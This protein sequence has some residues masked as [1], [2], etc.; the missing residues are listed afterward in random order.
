MARR[1]RMN[2]ATKS[3][4]EKH[5]EK[6]LKIDSK[7]DIM[8]RAHEMCRQFKAAG[9]KFD[10]HA[11]LGLNMKYLYEISK[12]KENNKGD[13]TMQ[14][15]NGKLIRVEKVNINAH[16][17][18]KEI[19][20][21]KSTRRG[22][23]EING[24]EYYFSANRFSSM[25]IVFGADSLDIHFELVKILNN[26]MKECGSNNNFFKMIT[27]VEHIMNDKTIYTDKISEG[28]LI[29]RDNN[30]YF[31]YIGNRAV[32]YREGVDRHPSSCAI[33]TLIK[34]LDRP[35]KMS[36][37]S[38][39]GAG[40]RIETELMPLFLSIVAE[41]KKASKSNATTNRRPKRRVVNN[42]TAAETP[43]ESPVKTEEPKIPQVKTQDQQPDNNSRRRRRRDRRI[44]NNTE[45]V[46]ENTE[47]KTP[48]KSKR[49]FDLRVNSFS[50][51]QYIDYIYKLQKRF[52]TDNS[53]SKIILD[54]ISDDPLTPSEFRCMLDSFDRDELTSMIRDNK[55][56]DEIYKSNPV[57]AQEILDSMGH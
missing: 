51:S 37:R 35:G 56:I 33:T 50:D 21:A 16:M 39:K 28:I 54:A 31:G 14:P 40:K 52:E 15:V 26:K 55:V 47:I 2:N 8:C 49:Y 5:E 24:K 38:M 7:K 57:V 13:V 3:I 53:I 25:P 12:L 44:N 6:Q 45:E 20:N 42:T 19:H 30:K 1:N 27:S 48:V 9:L 22:V 11:Q 41:L 46:I 10:Y 18:E 4:K 23:V 34:D 17:S 32:C 43:S 36:F 29:I